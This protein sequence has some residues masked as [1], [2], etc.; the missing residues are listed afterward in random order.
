M[1]LARAMVSDGA[2]RMTDSD[3]LQLALVE[4]CHP[5]NL[6]AALHGGFTVAWL[7]SDGFGDLVRMAVHPDVR[8]VVLVP[9]QELHTRTARA[10]LP[11]AVDFADAAA[12]IARAA[13]LVHALTVDPSRLMTA[14]EDRLH[15][16]ARAAAYPESLAAV[17]A[18]RGAGI[19]AVISGAGPT[20]L[21]LAATMTK[22]RVAGFVPNAGWQVSAVAVA[23]QGA[24][25]MPLPPLG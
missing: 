7:E 4:E 14:T 16:Q 1:V 13:L 15:Q 25:E 3:V 21:A 8:P 24:R 5:D 23:P 2:E 12:N 22:D 6:S 9:P 10:M 20:V 18:L 11:S 19:P 17:A